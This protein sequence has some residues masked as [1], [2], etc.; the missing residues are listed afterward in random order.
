MEQLFID[1]VSKYP[2][3]TMIFTA[4]GV[5]RAV[6]KPLMAVWESYV[7]STPTVNDDE[8]LKTFKSSGLYKA[9]AWIVDYAAS[10]KLPGQK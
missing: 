5:L 1:L 3:A 6:F 7:A 10:I 8:V 4:V 9:L 2:T